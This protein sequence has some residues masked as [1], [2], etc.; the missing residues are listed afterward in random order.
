METCHRRRLLC[1][2][3]RVLVALSGGA[4]STA[5][6]AVMAELREA[7]ELSYLVALHVDHG[8]R[9]DSAQDGPFCQELCGSLR[10]PLE[11]ISV[12]VA[13]GNVQAQARRARYSALQDAALKHQAT[14][15]A[16][17]HTR[18]DQAETVLLRLLRGSGARGLSGIPPKRGPFIRPL[19]DRDR[20]E[21]VAY[22]R[23]RGLP[24]REDPSNATPRFLRNRVR[25]EVV[26]LLQALNPAIDKALS[27][28]AD[29]LR[30]DERALLR[31]GRRLVSDPATV[32]LERL[33]SEPVAVRRRAIRV[34]WHRASGRSTDLCCHHVEA[35]LAICQRS[36]PSAVTLPSGF[37]ASCRYGRLLIGPLHPATRVEPIELPLPGPGSYPLPGRAVRL[38]IGAHPG[39]KL[40]WPFSLRHR[41]PGDRFR[42]KGGR[43][44]RK[45]KKWLID[46]KVPREERD[47]LLVVADA[48]GEILFLPDL[49]VSSAESALDFSLVPE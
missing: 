6:A 20:G 8:L 35:V 16:T 26:P 25:R 28:T 4:D 31:Q 11:R 33:L 9:P 43:G 30:G 27:R 29:L 19:I 38:V 47:G 24:W 23:A 14:R 1:R 34:L 36:R 12:K 10:I 44:S 45:L 3:D 49:G 21:V 32:D 7:G 40:H 2:G 48:T 15:I 22:L 37:E 39:A 46:R 18:T 17:G 13:P 41:L 5:L 42:P